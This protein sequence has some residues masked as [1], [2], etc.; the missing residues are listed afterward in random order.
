MQQH[1]S[2]AASRIARARRL[3]EQGRGSRHGSAHIVR[4]NGGNYTL[5]LDQESC[6]CPAGRKGV[7][8]YH[9][10][11]CELFEQRCRAAKVDTQEMPKRDSLKGVQVQQVNL[12]RLAARLGV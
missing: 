1:C 6:S 8:C 12:D 3:V 4:G 9:K 10:L 2:A 11:A 5:W 7:Y